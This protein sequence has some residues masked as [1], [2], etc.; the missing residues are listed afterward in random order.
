MPA[1]PGTQSKS[2]S[3]AVVAVVAVA[4]LPHE[5]VVIDVDRRVDA[6]A[7]RVVARIGRAGVVVV[8]VE[9]RFELAAELRVAVPDPQTRPAGEAVVRGDAALR[10]PGD[11]ADRRQAD[12]AVLAQAV[13]REVLAE[14]RVAAAVQRAAHVVPALAVGGARRRGRAAAEPHQ[15]LQPLGAAVRARLVGARAVRAVVDRAGDPVVAVPVAQARARTVGRDLA[16]SVVLE[17]RLRIPR[18]VCAA[19]RCRTGR[20]EDDQSGRDGPEPH[21]PPHA[22]HAVIPGGAGRSGKRGAARGVGTRPPAEAVGARIPRTAARC[23]PGCRRR[24]RRSA[25]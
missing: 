23:R 7:L 5:A 22:P 11:A 24:A 10:G 8:A 21:S 1:A 20:A 6:A 19:G 18:V 15:A 16:R 9:Q 13:L 2:S 14:R 3:I 4:R 25:W 17:R 12:L